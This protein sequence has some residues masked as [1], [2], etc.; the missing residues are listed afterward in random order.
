[1]EISSIPSY[2]DLGIEIVKLS[3]LQRQ[4]LRLTGKTVF[5][6]GPAGSGKTTFLNYFQ[7]GFFDEETKHTR[8]I[9]V[10]ST[11]TFSIRIGERSSLNLNVKKAIEIPG[12]LYPLQHARLAREYKPKCILLVADLC[13][14]DDSIEWLKQFCSS[15]EKEWLGK[16]NNDLQS[17]NII[18]NK[19]DKMN[20]DQVQYQAYERDVC[21]VIETLGFSIGTLP[22]SK[23][24]VFQCCLVNNTAGTRLVDRVIRKIALDLNA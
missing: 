16:K 14:K 18:L 1:M 10:S 12:Q 9:D 19:S 11:K 8:T 20:M 4:A 13:R 24:E 23:I 3:G 21:S 15:F 6:T 5:V 22:N 17:L 7:H 2:I